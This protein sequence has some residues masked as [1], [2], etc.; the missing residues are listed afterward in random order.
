MQATVPHSTIRR[1]GLT[2]LLRL[3]LAFA[4]VSA[5]GL[6][7][8]IPQHLYHLGYDALAYP[9]VSVGAAIRGINHPGAA[10]VGWDAWMR[11]PERTYALLQTPRY[12][13]M[14]GALLFEFVV[15]MA[16][17]A[18]AGWRVTWFLVTRLGRIQPGAPHGSA[19][20]MTDREM[21]ALAYR[22]GSL[23]LGQAGRH[24]VALDRELQTMNALLVG[25][26][27]S[28]KSSGF[29]IPNLLREP[30][31]RSLL[32]T[33]LKNELLQTTYRALEERHEVWVVNF[34][35]P[36]T[37]LGYNPLAY[38]VDEFSTMLFADAWIANTGKSEKEP[39]W[40]N[41]VRELLV[42]GIAHL[43]ATL[44]PRGETPT[45]AHLDDFLCNQAPLAVIGQLRSSASPLARKRA[46]GFFA[47]LVKNDKLLGSVFSEITPRL[48]IMADPRVQAT[49]SRNEVDF[50]RLAT[51]AG[52]PVAL[53]LALD[54]TLREQMKPLLAAFF[55]DFYRTLST[56]ADETPG[57]RLGRD[58]FVYGD[59]FGNIGAVPNMPMWMST[60]RSAGV[61]AVVVVQATAQGEELY[62]R[63]GWTT[64]KAACATKIGLSNMVDADAKW[65]SELSGQ[66]TVVAT[67]ASQQ[68]GRFH[69]VSD[70]GSRSEQETSRALLTVDEVRRLPEHELLA[71]IKALPPVR[72]EQ[73]RYYADAAVRERVDT[74]VPALGPARPTPLT[75]PPLTDPF[76]PADDEE[77]DSDPGQ[78]EHTHAGAVPN[79]PEATDAPAAEAG[80]DDD[81][82]PSID[83]MMPE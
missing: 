39:F 23:L 46:K 82:A 19:R 8:G 34:L 68:R 76:A 24:R 62:G 37:S 32:I 10:A 1:G 20:W 5:V 56:A 12:R 43:Q 63:E 78:P 64:I 22:K 72:L 65:F 75:A 15:V 66:A 77:R 30:G 38:C 83:D 49:T 47:S 74:R 80:G 16:L 14:Q 53:F 79:A 67:S 54:R 57:G 48:M 33:D 41:A 9:L 11:D 73:L 55:L 40:D 58:V 26:P 7:T 71:I 52:R 27:G 18:A 13:S 29:I 50:R 45:L 51:P 28:G 44:G 21:G 25:P 69:V 17:P 6:L 60:M 3:V 70:R 42:A 61:G 31:T 81:A 36:G 4:G 2:W 35:S 59:E